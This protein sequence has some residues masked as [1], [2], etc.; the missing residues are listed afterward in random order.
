MLIF[1]FKVHVKPHVYNVNFEKKVIKSTQ[2]SWFH[3]PPIQKLI[4]MSCQYVNNS[5]VM[6]DALHVVILIPSIH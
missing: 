4:D 6:R 5:F 3:I 2:W 1:S